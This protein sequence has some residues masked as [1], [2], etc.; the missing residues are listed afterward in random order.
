M[1]RKTVLT[2]AMLAALTGCAQQQDGERIFPWWGWLIVFIILAVIVWFIFR[3][4][5][6]E[7][8][9]TPLPVPDVKP[10]PAPAPVPVKANE[11]MKPLASASLKPDDLTTIEGIGPKI[12]SILHA[13]GVKTFS[14]LAA[15]EPEQIKEIIT[16][17]GLRLADTT[18]WPDQARLAA[19]GEMDKLQI[20]QDSLKGGRVV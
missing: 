1:F 11:V 3:T 18:T 17:A 8:T 9:K 20:Y 16:N 13:A 10:T 6:E 15:M 7:E 19:S 14:D 2:M 12:K 5:P 4:R